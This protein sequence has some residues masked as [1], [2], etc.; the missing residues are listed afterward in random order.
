M[1]VR[2]IQTQYPYT[3]E[4]DYGDHLIQVKSHYSGQDGHWWHHVCIGRRGE[5]MLKVGNTHKADLQREVQN[6]GFAFGR[7]AIDDSLLIKP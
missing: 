6:Q 3:E 7:A 4:D 1:A 2:V 5:E